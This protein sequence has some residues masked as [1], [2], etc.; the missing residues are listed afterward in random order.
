MAEQTGIAWCDHTF[1]PWIGCTKVSAACDFCYAEELM[2]HRYHRVEWGGERKRTSVSNWQ[3]PF[4][5]N[6]ASERDGVRR[7][8]FTLSLG[9]FFD[10]Q[11]PESWRYE[12]WGIIHACKNLDWLILTKRPQNIHKMLPDGIAPWSDGPWPHVW[13]GTTVENQEEA[14]RRIPALRSV[15]AAIRF[16]SVEPMLGPVDLREHLVD[17]AS[18]WMIS[19]TPAIDWVICGGE[20]GKHARAFDVGWARSLRDQCHAAGTAFFMKQMDRRKPIPDD[21][22]IREFPH[23][24]RP[25]TEET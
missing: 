24:L 8:V 18:D 4:R 20:S 12:A 22:F 13:L 9:D 6:R 17:P 5:W 25:V 19:P 16:L 11:V 21:L 15:P 7:K 2:D 23:P 1:N 10:N 14:N 3:Q